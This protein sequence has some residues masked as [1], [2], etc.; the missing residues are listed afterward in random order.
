MKSPTINL[1]KLKKLFARPRQF[2]ADAALKKKGSGSV[3]EQQQIKQALTCFEQGETQKAWHLLQSVRS[4]L[5]TKWLA[6]ARLAHFRKDP[7]S[8]ERSAM[9]AL[10]LL[11]P[12]TSIFGDA[13]YLHQESLRQQ[14]RYQD[15]LDLLQHLPFS[16]NSSRFYRALRLACLGCGQ[17]ST[18][19]RQLILITPDR[20]DWLRARNHYLLLLRDLGR[21]QQA[22]AE[23][24][25]LMS[26]ALSRPQG[27]I[28]SSVPSGLGEQQKWQ[29]KAGLALAQLKEDL[30]KEGVNFFL[31]SGTLLGCIRENKI[32]G[33]DTDIDVGVMPE[34]SISV[35]RNAIN[36]SDRFILQETPGKQTLYLQ[37][38]NGVKIDLF[39]HYQENN[40]LYHGGIKCRWWNTPF[41]LIQQSFL[42]QQYFVPENSDIYLTENYGNW[43]T[44]IMDFET[45]LDTPNM[46]VTEPI[47]MALYFGAQCIAAHR[48]GRADKSIKYLQAFKQLIPSTTL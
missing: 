15:A 26:Q 31:V 5:P 7:A 1:N 42:G 48:N 36:Q 35:L 9:H 44:P 27:K 38:A 6:Q 18:F 16:D 28:Q 12:E 45:F 39:R 32:L 37:H 34:V 41:N 2:F 10:Q 47:K 33:H 40:I 29:T 11:H 3:G 24:E 23:L 17:A 21:E 46:E 8:A 13:F 14:Q 30:G 19:E 43:R 20:P 4:S 22:L 25:L